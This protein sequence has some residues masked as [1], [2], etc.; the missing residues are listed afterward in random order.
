LALIWAQLVQDAEAALGILDLARIT[1]RVDLSLQLVLLGDH[2]VNGRLQAG[3]IDQQGE[4]LLLD[5][6]ID[7][8]LHLGGRRPGLD[9]GLGLGQQVQDEVQLV[10]NVVQVEL[11]VLGQDAQPLDLV[12][13]VLERGQRLQGHNPSGEAGALHLR[14]L[15]R[16][17]PLDLHPLQP[18]ELPLNAR[19]LDLHLAQLA[20]QQLLHRLD[21]V[22][23]ELRP[24]ALQRQVRTA[25]VV[26]N[27]EP[28][29]QVY[30]L[31]QRLR[32]GGIILSS[33]VLPSVGSK[34]VSSVVS[35]V[36]NRPQ[37]GFE[38]GAKLVGEVVKDGADRGHLL[39]DPHED[40]AVPGEV[41]QARR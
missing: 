8:R 18:L 11:R 4:L 31:V 5:R 17:A 35:A 2:L 15:L 32:I 20:Q 41:G 14:D 25:E 19:Q 16:G 36:I 9:L 10:V 3:Q 1:E 12:Q 39:A 30:A 26:V 37:R 28:L 13:D 34:H 23:D 38:I 27:Q 7:E 24:R 33:G 21:H 40:A 22:R 29:R 6:Q